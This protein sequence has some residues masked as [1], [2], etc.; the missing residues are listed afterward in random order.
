ME[1]RVGRIVK[2]KDYTHFTRYK[3]QYAEILDDPDEFGSVVL[4]WV[5]DK[6]G[7]S[8][9]QENLEVIKWHTV[10]TE[11][12]NL[13]EGNLV[14][15]NGD[16][17]RTGVWIFGEIGEKTPTKMYIWN[18]QEE[19]NY[20][21]KAPIGYKYAW[22]ITATCIGKI[23]V[24]KE[25]DIPDKCHSCN[26]H[27]EKDKLEKCIDA[28]YYCEDCKNEQFADCTECNEQVH[29]DDVRSNDDGD[30]Y[31]DDCYNELYSTCAGCDEEVRKENEHL[32]EDTWWCD[33]CFNDRFTCCD[34]CG[35]IN[36]FDNLIYD[37]EADHH[38]CGNC[39]RKKVKR[40]IHDYGYIP[41]FEF[42]RLNWDEPLYMGVELEVQRETDYDEYATKF[43]K[44]LKEQGTDKHFY[45]KHDG[46]LRT[47]DNHTDFN[48]FEMV[49][50]PFTLQYAH[51]NL[52]FNKILKWLKDNKYDY[53]E[54]TQRCGLHIHISRNFF[55][56]MD[57]TKL[58][59]FFRQNQAEI[60]KFSKRKSKTNEYCKYETIDAIEMAKGREQEGNN[61][62]TA[63][64]AQTAKQTVEIRVFNSTLD[65]ARFIAILQFVDALAH[66]VKV[67]GITSLLLG[68]GEY[69]KNSWKLFID[70]AKADGKYEAMLQ[71]LHKEK[72]IKA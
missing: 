33:D 68:E 19:G 65:A 14:L 41:K 29:V 22:A 25:S 38:Y 71:Q 8:A 47:E 11:Y 27:F 56:E 1:L 5:I 23:I 13:K 42:S 55:E 67:V 72:L 20:G 40:V 34:N 62:H 10:A 24:V 63:I 18:N 21:T 36:R 52:G 54:Q 43:L 9:N 48:G 70:W 2:L 31:C 28:K 15:T 17:T 51:K 26:E 45:L 39:H 16:G 64:D 57:V 49:T 61:H 12:E 46:T 69:H 30:E 32:A 37:E 53:G 44:F 4:R 35:G 59:I 66:F 50:Q 7:F 60:F 6:K 3:D 58:R